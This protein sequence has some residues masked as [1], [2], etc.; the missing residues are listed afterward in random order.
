MKNELLRIRVTAEER[1]EILARA[2][3]AG[4]APSAYARG[5]A[6]ARLVEPRK[7]L[8]DEDGLE[9]I[10]QCGRL[11]KKIYAGETTVPAEKAEILRKVAAAFGRLHDH[12]AD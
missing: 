10:R 4:L 11:L 9:E 1:K 8:L 2:E 12:Q 6:M 7:P 3:A 5:K